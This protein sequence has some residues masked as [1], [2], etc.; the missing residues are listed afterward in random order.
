LSCWSNNMAGPMELCAEDHASVA[1][2]IRDMNADAKKCGWKRLREGWVCPECLS[3]PPRNSSK[4]RA[5]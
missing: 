1:M 2:T 3:S 5:T 4:Q